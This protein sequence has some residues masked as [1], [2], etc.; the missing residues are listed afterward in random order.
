MRLCG[1]M[2]CEV[3]P[4][5]SSCLNVAYLRMTQGEA[6]W[7]WRE[8]A[9][10]RDTRMDTLSEWQM[11]GGAAC[12]ASGVDCIKA[13]AVEGPPG[14]E[15]AARGRNRQGFVRRGELRIGRRAMRAADGEG[16]LPTAGDTRPPVN[17]GF[18][19]ASDASETRRRPTGSVAEN[20]RRSGALLASMEAVTACPHDLIYEV[21]PADQSELPGQ[22]AVKGKTVAQLKHLARVVELPAAAVV[23]PL[24]HVTS[25]DLLR[26]HARL[27]VTEKRGRQRHGG[28][29]G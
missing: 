16:D 8:A 20:R 17:G 13:L 27:S 4:G 21:E 12:E 18:R 26:L 2:A 6:V 22:V 25:D 15:F 7:T 9:T 11:A 14:L 3:V 1:T 10:E 24:A 28:G 5:S 29:Q 23:A 19:P